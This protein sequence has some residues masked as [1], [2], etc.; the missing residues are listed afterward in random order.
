MARQSSERCQCTE[1]LIGD[2]CRRGA[3]TA[4]SM[5][6]C[7]QPGDRLREVRLAGLCRDR[8][9]RKPRRIVGGRRDGAT[10]KSAEEQTRLLFKPLKWLIRWSNWMGCQHGRCGAVGYR[11]LQHEGLLSQQAKT[12][13]VLANKGW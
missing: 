8:Y 13:R 7:Q 6:I 10:A 9:L 2:I 4:I 5:L 12:Y 1:Y 11:R 3:P